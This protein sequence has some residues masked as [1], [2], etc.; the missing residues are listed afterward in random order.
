MKRLYKFLL[1]GFG[2]LAVSGFVLL[3]AG[4]EILM[5]LA[6]SETA[7]FPDKVQE[8]QTCARLD[9]N[10][11]AVIDGMAIIRN[12]GSINLEELTISWADSAGESSEK[13]LGP[14]EPTEKTSI[15]LGDV[16]EASLETSN[17]GTLDTYP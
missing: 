16:S 17:C 12:T 5:Y 3:F 7:D 14:L 15:E 10:I 2:L 6:A 4:P 13:T 8:S 9:A 11:E 1:A